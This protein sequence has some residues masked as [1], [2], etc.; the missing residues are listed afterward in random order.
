MFP[1]SLWDEEFEW[2]IQVNYDVPKDT[3]LLAINDITFL[4]MPYQRD[5]IPNGPQNIEKGL[6]ILDGDEVSKGF[7]QFV[8]FVDR[9]FYHKRQPT[10]D[11]HIGGY[12]MHPFETTSSET[13]NSVISF[14]GCTIDV[15]QG[16][17]RLTIEYYSDTNELQGWPLEQLVLKSPK[18]LYL[19]IFFLRTTPANVSLLLDFAAQAVTNSSCLNTLYIGLTRSSAEDGDKFM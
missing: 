16:L 17:K 1:V 10:N 12:L 9:V 2:K 4:S 3:F 11:I 19:W 18:L 15:E 6:I 7:I 13:I 8:D 5:I 14:L